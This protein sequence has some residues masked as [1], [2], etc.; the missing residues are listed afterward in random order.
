MK[1]FDVI[2]TFYRESLRGYEQCDGDKMYSV[3]ARNEDAAKRKVSKIVGKELKGPWSQNCW[4][5]IK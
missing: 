2:V 3:S 4:F 1:H 5:K